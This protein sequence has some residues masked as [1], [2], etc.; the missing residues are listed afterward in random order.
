V[1]TLVLLALFLVAVPV[2]AETQP[3]ESVEAFELGLTKCL[4][5]N[6]S[7]ATC[8]DA[9]MRGHFPRGNERLDEH[10]AQLR[11]LFQRWLGKDKVYAVHVVMTTKLGTY[12]DRRTYLI[13]DTSGSVMMLDATFVRSV[14]KWHLLKFNLTNQK[15]ELRTVLGDVL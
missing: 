9:H 7:P 6:P 11:E 13:E 3:L 12:A 2:A 8:F 5:A 4:L 10:V 14:G 1:R 15:D